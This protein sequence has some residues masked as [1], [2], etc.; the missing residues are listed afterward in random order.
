MSENFIQKL[1]MYAQR[2]DV[3]AAIPV[4]TDGKNHIVHAGYAVNPQGAL[5][6]RNKGLRYTAGGWHLLAMQSHNVATMAMVCVMVRR[7]AWTPL[8]EFDGTACAGADWGL[9]LLQK[10]LH[11]VYTPHAHAVCRDTHVLEIPPADAQ[12]IA[13]AWQGFHDP[14][15]PAACDPEKTD[16]SLRRKPL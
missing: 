5:R 3:G 6:C 15:Y 1:L 4:L 11:H 13:A 9:R 7:D 8:Q 10:G 2:P 14:C 16:F 12:R